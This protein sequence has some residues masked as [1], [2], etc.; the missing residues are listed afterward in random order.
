MRRCR[1]FGG[2]LLR[3]SCELY[4]P[5]LEPKPGDEFIV[6]RYSVK[7]GCCNFEPTDI[8]PVILEMQKEHHFE[9]R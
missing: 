8:R 3:E 6:E 4:Q 2:C 5:F 7:K 9:V 1:G